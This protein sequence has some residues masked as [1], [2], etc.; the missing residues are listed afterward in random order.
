MG[1]G[2]TVGPVDFE[3]LVQ[4][5][6]HVGVR[7]GRH[8]FRTWPP[9]RLD[10]PRGYDRLTTVYIVQLFNHDEWY[11]M[12]AFFRERDAEAVQRLYE[13]EGTSTRIT[14]V[15]VHARV[16]DWAFDR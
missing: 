6:R 2:I 16:E 1:A 3:L 12:A 10:L 4:G 7:L 5:P 11:D 8:F 14:I 9:Y 13:A 15:P